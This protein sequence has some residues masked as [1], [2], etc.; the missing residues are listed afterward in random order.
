[1]PMGS[2]WD[3]VD[4]FWPRITPIFRN[5]CSI[6]GV[7]ICPKVCNATP[8]NRNRIPTVWRLLQPGD[9]THTRLPFHRIEAIFA[10]LAVQGFVFRALPSGSGYF[11]ICDQHPNPV[12]PRLPAVPAG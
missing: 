7:N 6:F 9:Q 3:S 1:M 8:M 4:L 12:I 5:L 11:V 2:A 10:E